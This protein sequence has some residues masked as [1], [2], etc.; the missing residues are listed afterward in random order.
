MQFTWMTVL[1]DW[2]L[3]K[4]AP[5][6]LLLIAIACILVATVMASG[7]INSIRTLSLAGIAVAL[8]SALLYAFYI[9]ANSRAGKEIPTIKR[10]AIMV[11]GAAISIF[12]VNSYQVVEQYS[13]KLFLF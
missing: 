5:G 7:E 2:Y 3:L 10:S 4:S 6:A 8:A 9:I 11:T 13:V 12:L 1:L